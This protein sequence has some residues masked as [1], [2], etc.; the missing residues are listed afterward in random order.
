MIFNNEKTQVFQKFFMVHIILFERIYSLKKF[1]NCI[2]IYVYYNLLFV[3]YLSVKLSC[4]SFSSNFF[5]INQWFASTCFF[6]TIISLFW[7]MKLDL[8]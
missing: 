4:C 3:N 5:T 7:N 6:N 1:E 2:Y 8:S